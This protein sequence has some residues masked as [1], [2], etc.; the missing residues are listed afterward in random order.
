AAGEIVDERL[1]SRIAKHP[2]HLLLERLRIAQLAPDG[3]VAQV[4]VWDAAPEEEREARC[5][6]EI[7]QAIGGAAGGSGRL[8]FDSKEEAG[9]GEDALDAALDAGVEAFLPALLV[10][11]HERIDVL[12]GERPAVSPRRERRQNSSRAGLVRRGVRGPADED[13]AAAR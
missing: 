4:V 12:F 10:E 8:A 1:R 11:T 7:A 2:L 9:S 5:Q 13:L 6:L 3:G